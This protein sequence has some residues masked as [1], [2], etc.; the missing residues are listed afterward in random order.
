MNQA[1]ARLPVF[2]AVL[3][4]IGFLAVYDV[5]AVA[6]WIMSDPWFAATGL[7]AWLGL[8]GK[9]WNPYEAEED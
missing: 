6:A 7:V 3:R 5:G 8:L 9:S 1:L 4:A 2:P